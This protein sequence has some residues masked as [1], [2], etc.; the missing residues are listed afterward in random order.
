MKQKHPHLAVLAGLLL[1]VTTGQPITSLAASVDEQLQALQ[2]DIPRQRLP[3]PDFALRDLSGRTVRLNDYKG[4]LILLN[5]WATFCKPCRDEMPAL[6][7]LAHDFRAQGLAVLAVA[8]DRGNRN[9]VQQFVSEHDINFDVPLDPDGQVRNDYE[10]DALP[11]S[12][13]IGKDGRFIARALGDRHWDNTAFRSLIGA[14][15]TE[16]TEVAVE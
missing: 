14:L 12:Y 16:D 1:A 10:I 9:S 8:V 5:F 4:Q 2:L 7:A 15:L 3:A 11:T 6:A 13:L